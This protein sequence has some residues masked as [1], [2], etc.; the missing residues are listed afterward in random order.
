MQNMKPNKKISSIL[1]NNK[2]KNKKQT[3]LINFSK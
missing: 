3:N 2:K 1:I